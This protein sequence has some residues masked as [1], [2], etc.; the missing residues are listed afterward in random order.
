MKYLVKIQKK[1]KCFTKVYHFFLKYISIGTPSKLYSF[2]IQFSIKR[3]YGSRTY[4][5]KLQYKAKEGYTV[6]NC[7]TYFMRMYFPLYVGGGEFLI[8]SRR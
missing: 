3:L 6:G 4:C 2:L 5:G 7:V 8:I 1:T